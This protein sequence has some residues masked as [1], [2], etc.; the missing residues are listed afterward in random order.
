[1]SVFNNYAR[2][3]DLL[4]RDKDYLAE[5]QYVNQHIQAFAPGAQSLL[6]LGCGTGRHATLL[7]SE[8]YTI[9]GLDQSMEMIRR[10]RQRQ[11][12]LPSNQGQRLTFLHGDIQSFKTDTRFDAVISLFHVISYQTTNEDLDATFFTA[13]NHLKPGGIFLF[14][15]WYGPAV[16]TE[17]PDV[18][19]KRIEDDTI[20]ITRIAEP[21]IHANE[22]IVDVKYHV[23]IRDQTTEQVN[24]IH[25]THRMRYLFFPEIERLFSANNMKLI[26]AEEWM[27]GQLL[28]VDTWNAFF[29]GRI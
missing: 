1:M 21:E 18:R 17:L 26:H 23:F 29:I 20:G 10:A 15:C 3:Y 16:L 4:Y 6:E 7:S 9:Y 13:S 8:N 5:T 27:T 28:G 22:N 11:A 12:E 2:Y 19:V 14:D 24:E 25:E